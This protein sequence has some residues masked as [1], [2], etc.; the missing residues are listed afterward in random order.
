M[1]QPIALTDAAMCPGIV[2]LAAVVALRALSDLPVGNLLAWSNG[3]IAIVAL[4]SLSMAMQRAAGT[5]AAIV[6]LVAFFATPSFDRTLAPAAGLAL[7]ACVSLAWHA[8]FSASLDPRASARRAAAPAALVALVSPALLLPCLALVASAVWLG[9]G[10]SPRRR[11]LVIVAATL[12]MAAATTALVFSATRQ[13]SMAA[14]A[15]CVLPSSAASGLLRSENSLMSAAPGPLPLGLAMLGAF[16]C[17]ER[18]RQWRTWW[19]VA[20]AAVPVIGGFAD[21]GMLAPVCAGV[22]CLS[23]IGLSELFRGS[24]G[25]LKIVVPG[26]LIASL[27]ILLE[28]RRFNQREAAHASLT[29]SAARRALRALPTAAI[30]AEDASVNLLLRA[31][32]PHLDAIGK[33][34]Q[35]VAPTPA[36]VTAATESGRVFAYPRAR[37][38][39]Q[40][41]G[42]SFAA[43]GADFPGVS[44]VKTI[45]PCAAI[46]SAWT[47]APELHGVERFALVAS[48]F[49]ARGP[50]AV[51]TGTERPMTAAPVAWPLR[52]TRGFV[53]R[54][55]AR[56]ERPDLPDALRAEGVPETSVLLHMPHVARIVLWRT[57]GA[58]TMLP[59]DLGTA[60][61]VVLTRADPGARLDGLR[62]CPAFN[63]EREPAQR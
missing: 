11:L 47:P 43:A 4:T 18:R 27:L 61:A 15:S 44:E 34:L 30:V 62:L 23:A 40:H 10:G 21:P 39:L 33:P 54:T 35:I 24:H 7:V 3:I 22:W 6:A 8:L 36:A 46:Q 26:L 42:V 25:R 19:A 1:R 16:A 53:L 13:W 51:Y 32:A 63:D 49:D 12:G 55:Y 17:L 48:A 38:V 56:A 14:L 45:V 31:A 41:Q 37:S 57:P 5:L 52:T 60:P 9:E 29:A 2:D 58:P 28:A 50:V 59:V 20:L